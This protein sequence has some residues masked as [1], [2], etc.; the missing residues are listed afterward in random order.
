MATRKKASAKET[1]E[2]VSVTVGMLMRH[3]TTITLFGDSPL[4]VNAWSQKAKL[5]M[6]TKHM[7]MTLVREAKDPWEV[8]RA[9]QYRLKDGNY[10]FPVVSVKEAMATAAVDIANL[11]KAVV[12]R[13][14][15]TKGEEGFEKSAF[16]DL[17]SPRELMPIYSPNAPALRED[18][19]KLSGIG[20]TPDLRYRAQYWPWAARFELAF[21]EGPLS[22]DSIMNL[23]A[24]AGFQVGLGEW[25]Q[26]R[27]GVHGAFH[28]D[29]T[30]QEMT[31]VDKW[32]KAGPQEPTR[33]DIEE[34]LSTFRNKA[35]PEEAKP[36]KRL[37]VV[38]GSKRR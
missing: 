26:E 22:A 37:R 33:P 24:H 35:K 32:I 25:R 27:G 28:H 36:A 18:M 5:E 29:L 23:L 6:L 7:N 12:Y 19:V 4:I 15:V 30:A 16:M 20:R 1:A 17:L 13:N 34:W 9:S 21:C 2:S 14:I 8:F 11:S 31:L 38:V 10:G 3:K